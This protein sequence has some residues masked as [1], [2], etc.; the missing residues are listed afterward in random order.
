ML[1]RVAPLLNQHFGEE[2]VFRAGGDEFVIKAENKTEES[3]KKATE[4]FEA[5]P[6][7]SDISVALELE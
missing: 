2:K 4:A 6:K 7:Q 1:N 3:L 5:E